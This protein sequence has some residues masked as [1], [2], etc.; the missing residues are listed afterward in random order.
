MS[1]WFRLRYAYFLKCERVVKDPAT[2]EVVELHGTYDPA[3]R[4]GNSPDGRKVKATIH[5][6]SAAQAIPAEARIYEQLFTVLDPLSDK[7]KEFTNFMS[8]KSLEVL[9]GCQL[10]PGLAFAKPGVA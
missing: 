9:T 10:E 6:V 1:D 2:G 4:G 5:W 3:S 7:E 8:N